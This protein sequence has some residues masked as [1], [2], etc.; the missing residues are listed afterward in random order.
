LK[1]Q[2]PL[3]L[4]AAI[5]ALPPLAV[6]M[7]LPAIPGIADDLATNISTVQ[8]SLSIFLVGFGLGLL[9][10][11]P[12]SDRHGR[13]P[14]AFVGLLG[15]AMASCLIA[16]AS[17][18]E[19][20]LVFR[21]LQGFLGSAASVTVP[22]MI[23][24]CYGKN[25]AKGMSHV[26]MIMLLAPL[27]APLMGSLLLQ[28]GPWEIIFVLM[29]LYGLVLCGMAFVRLPETRPLPEPGYQP[30]SLL[31]NY[32]LILS[33]RIIYPDLLT[34]M[35]AAFAFFTYLTSVSFV[36]ITWFGVS[37][38]VFG[39]LFACTA[40]ALIVANYINVR[41][42][43]RLGSRRMLLGALGCGT[44]FALL[45]LG[46]NMLDL[47]IG[48]T[49]LCYVFII[50]SFGIISVNGD[51][52]ILVQFPHQ[53][54]SASAVTGTLRFGSGAMAGP[55]LAIYYDGTPLPV[56]WL[57]AGALSLACG[58][59]WLRYWLSRQATSV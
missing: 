15:F 10:F 4:L 27:V 59:Q 52:L 9:F 18:A 22:G 49:V 47:A 11:G 5:A 8:N 56:A 7:Y 53:A 24:D 19:S 55:L 41:L 39:L 43:S 13:R 44:L 45:L 31:G 57:I 51:S 25:T 38:T 23:R 6:D 1:I 34:F 16:L 37:E 46:V 40:S 29:S 33:Q 12:L 54:S 48:W 28:L 20:F 36:Y 14:L 2:P 32:R 17:S 3:L 30:P 42:V 35:L 58:C 50:G 21:L 26:I